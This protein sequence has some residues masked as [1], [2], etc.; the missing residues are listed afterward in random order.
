MFGW[1]VLGLLAFGCSKTWY[2]LEI[3]S[4]GKGKC[5]KR[6]QEWGLEKER[7]R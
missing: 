3:F 4:S 7:R 1:I 6:S 2:T 5:I